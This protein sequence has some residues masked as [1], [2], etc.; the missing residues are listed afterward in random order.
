MKKYI[1]ILRLFPA[2]G[3]ALA[4][5]ACQM[6][7]PIP[8][9]YVYHSDLYK[10]PP[11]AAPENIGMPWSAQENER[12]AAYWRVAARDLVKRLVHEGLNGEQGPIYIVPAEPDDPLAAIFE[13]YL[14][15]AILARGVP[16]AVTPGKGPVL[17]VD[18]AIVADN[19]RAAQALVTPRGVVQP[20]MKAPAPSVEAPVSILPPDGKAA[21]SMDLPP[22]SVPHV[23]AP[24]PA[25]AA[26]KPG[27]HDTIAL[28]L[29]LLDGEAS[30]GQWGGVYVVP[31]VDSYRKPLLLPDMLRP[32]VGGR[33]G[34]KSAQE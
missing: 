8:S 34:S 30:L 6:P 4:V 31:G 20:E 25:M 16:L 14:R 2:F 5:S 15:E 1:P 29:D 27:V 11:A 3:I 18:L 13:N 7:S 33:P 28:R 22:V 24:K 9:G 17:N 23:P 10:S 21:P 26:L 32:V 12:A 19:A